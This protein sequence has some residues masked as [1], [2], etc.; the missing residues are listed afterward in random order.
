MCQLSMVYTELDHKMVD[1]YLMDMVS[2]VSC[3]CHLRI[4]QVDMV[5][6]WL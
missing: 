2:T 1:R 5:Y 3:G 6:M 4:D